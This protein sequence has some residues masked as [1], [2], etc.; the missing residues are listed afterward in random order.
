MIV[1]DTSAVIALLNAEPEAPAMEAALAATRDRH[2]G[3]A[4]LVET[5]MVASR[6]GDAVATA[7]VDALLAALQVEIVAFDAAQSVVA[8]EAF[9]KFG[10]GRGHRAQL[11]LSDCFSY[12]LAKTL[13]AP[14]LFKGRDF[15]K[16]DVKRAI[17]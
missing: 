8:R 3:A 15:S 6:W 10:K 5:T 11:N 7:G 1:L 12:A 9:L 16:T 4:T 13:D 14:L 17:S 2:I